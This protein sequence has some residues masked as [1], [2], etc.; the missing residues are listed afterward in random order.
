M[1]SALV[2]VAVLAQV[3]LIEEPNASVTVN[4][5]TPKAVVSINGVDADLVGRKIPVTA[6]DRPLEVAVN[7]EGYWDVFFD[8]PI[9]KGQN[10]V[11]RVAALKPG[12]S[13]MDGRLDLEKDFD[14]FTNGLRGPLVKYTITATAD[15]VVF[16]G[17]FEGK[18]T[19]YGTRRLTSFPYMVS[20]VEYIAE[21]GSELTTAN[22]L[23]WDGAPL[24]IDGKP[25]TVIAISG[26]IKAWTIMDYTQAITSRDTSNPHVVLL[27]HKPG[28]K[29]TFI[30]RRFYG[31]QIDE[32]TFNK[33]AAAYGQ[34]L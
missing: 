22:L 2:F 28:A 33:L 4:C 24:V 14:R 30:L 31:K 3:E 18:W 12:V 9:K 15:Q 17:P 11:L 7:C 16:K 32:A 27:N 26:P 10:L 34:V 23:G 6:S 19:S 25:H 21:T 1:F 8:L 20:R 29:G 5:P 13:M